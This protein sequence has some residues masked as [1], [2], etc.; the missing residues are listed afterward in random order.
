MR[1]LR[2]KEENVPSLKGWIVTVSPALSSKSGHENRF[3][4]QGGKCYIELKF[5]KLCKS[6]GVFLMLMR[7]ISP[8]LHSISYWLYTLLSSYAHTKKPQRSDPKE[9]LPWL[10]ERI[11]KITGWHRGGTG[12]VWGILQLLMGKWREW[13]EQLWPNAAIWGIY[14]LTGIR[15]ASGFGGT[16]GEKPHQMGACS[17]TLLASPPW[18]GAGSTPTA[19]C[20][21]Y[22]SPPL[23]CQWQHLEKLSNS[24]INVHMQICWELMQSVKWKQIPLFWCSWY[25][26]QFSVTIPK[27]Y[28]EYWSI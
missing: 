7:D 18:L 1:V 5:I 9:V 6:R 12:H 14:Q 8:H 27:G 2:S 25:V 4:F 3:G 17:G 11:G 15:A 22:V 26:V 23:Q 19:G 16:W 13:F 20:W 21:Q 10:H 24:K 28:N